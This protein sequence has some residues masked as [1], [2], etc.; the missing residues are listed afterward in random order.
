MDLLALSG[1]PA[2]TAAVRKAVGIW[3]ALRQF[4]VCMDGRFAAFLGTVGSDD[5]IRRCQCREEAH[6]CLGVEGWQ[7]GGLPGGR[8]GIVK[9][10]R[11]IVQLGSR[12]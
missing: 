9:V 10:R 4:R 8:G 6:T 2:P 7:G 11:L 5:R 12:C 1:S 3:A